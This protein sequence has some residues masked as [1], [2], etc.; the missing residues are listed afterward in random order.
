MNNQDYNDKCWKFL[1]A[2]VKDNSLTDQNFKE[3]LKEHHTEIA[4][5][6][7]HV[8]AR[9][10]KSFAWEYNNIKHLP[11]R[12]M[13]W[14]NGE[15][16]MLYDWYKCESCGT[17]VKTTDDIDECTYV[18]PLCPNCND[19]KDYPYHC[20]KSTVDNITSLFNKALMLEYFT[21]S[22]D[23]H[24]HTNGMFVQPIFKMGKFKINWFSGYRSWKRYQS[25]DSNPNIVKYYAEY[26]KLKRKELTAK[27][28]W[29]W[30]CKKYSD[31]IEGLKL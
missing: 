7:K 28:V 9:N 1:I 14:I 26:V 13:K 17:L 24:D 25:K 12:T 18:L 4:E 5:N 8:D 23:T 16:V 22:N 20:E 11:V 10:I 30:H 21:A 19:I 15:H 3:K 6:N 29:D 31:K 27:Y 2:G